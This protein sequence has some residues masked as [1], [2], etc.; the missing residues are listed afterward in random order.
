[1]VGEL[2]LR[3]LKMMI[4]PLII[5]AIISVTSSMDPK[6]NGRISAVC[7]VYTLVCNFVPSIIG[8]VLCMAIGPGYAVKDKFMKVEH[9]SNNSSPTDTSDVL[10]DL[11]RNFFPDNIIEAT[12]LQTQT[13][14]TVKPAVQI[15][16]IV[17]GTFPL[18][19]GTRI[20]QI[21]TVRSPNIIGL[22][23]ICTMFGI[24][25]G[26]LRDVSKPFQA[27]FNAS[28][29]VIMQ[30]LRWIMWVTP[31]GVASLIAKTI[32]SAENI[33][34]DFQKLGMFI[35]AVTTGL[36][37]CG[38][39]MPISYAIL[40]RTNPFTFILSLSQ[41]IMLAFA[42]ANSPITMPA[43][44]TILETDCAVD[45]RVSRFVMPFIMTLGRT[46]TALYIAMS[47]I[48]VC[49][50]MG[51]L[52]NVANVMLICLL[53]TITSTGAPPVPSSALMAVIIVTAALNIPTEAVTLLYTFDWFI[54]RIRSIVNLLFQAFAAVLT[55]DL[56]GKSLSSP[57]NDISVYESLTKTF[58]NID[59]S[60]EIHID[61]NELREPS[62]SL[63]DIADV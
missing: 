63:S 62:G 10:A 17:N 8:C 39:L 42:T 19:T 22:V 3:V 11:L 40:R 52:L 20:R 4:V 32:C 1:M 15:E 33:E 49:Q 34:A 12:F 29:E 35:L 27:F 47:A 30:V 41:P 13:T 31:I 48:F 60:I 6:S 37:M 14:Y 7:V 28:G 9:Q 56:C 46:G 16:F 21:S 45:K 57:P 24:A 54:D 51:T 2:Y 44:M 26:V 43:V 53:T 59:N 58:P 5:T 18:L 36:I 50:L 55:Q 25:S 23:V 38:L 61:E